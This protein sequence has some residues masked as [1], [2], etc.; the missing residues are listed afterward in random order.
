MGNRLNIL[1]LSPP[2]WVLNRAQTE[3]KGTGPATLLVLSQPSQPSQP[4]HPPPQSAIATDVGMGKRLNI[5]IL[6]PHLWFL[7]Q[8]QTVSTSFYLTSFHNHRD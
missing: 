1:I 4:L 3:G 8:N 6:L 2:I 5:F 7:N